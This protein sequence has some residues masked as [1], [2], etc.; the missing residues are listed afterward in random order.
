MIQCN[1]L[2]I[3]Q[4][5]NRAVPPSKKHQIPSRATQG[6]HQPVSVGAEAHGGTLVP[7][8][9]LKCWKHC[10]FS[11]KSVEQY[12]NL[13]RSIESSQTQREH[14]FK[15]QGKRAPCKDP[16]WQS[17]SL[18]SWAAG[19]TISSR[20]PAFNSSLAELFLRTGLFEGDVSLRSEISEWDQTSFFRVVKS[21]RIIRSSG[22]D[23]N[24]LAT[25]VSIAAEDS[26]T[27]EEFDCCCCVKSPTGGCRVFYPFH[28]QLSMPQAEA[29]G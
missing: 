3:V 25:M 23:N 5:F 11:E 10:R 15:S 7:F 12:R 8:R 21:G 18:P 1:S 20:L 13:Y 26:A 9:K 27:P 19:A 14:D 16:I 28:V 6:R 29:I 22:N 4:S 24:M 17:I 2:A